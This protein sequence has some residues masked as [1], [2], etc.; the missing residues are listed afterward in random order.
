VLL[1]AEHNTANVFL[2]ISPPSGVAAG[3][4][5]WALTAETADHPLQAAAAQLT[6][7]RPRLVAAT[8][9][10]RPVRKRSRWRVALITGLL[11]AW[12]V[13]LKLGI[14]HG[15]H[16]GPSIR[17]AQAEAAQGETAQGE[18]ASEPLVPN[19]SR[20]P[21]EV[22]GQISVIAGT[23]LAATEG[24]QAEV[25]RL[26]LSALSGSRSAGEQARRTG[27]RVRIAKD[28]WTVRLP[29]GLFTVTFHLKGFEPMSVLVDT[30]TSGS[31]QPE[32]I[33]LIS[34]PV[35][36]GTPTASASGT[37]RAPIG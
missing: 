27:H 13:A 24:V 10:P 20:Q 31:P 7:Q 9:A 14:E 1:L 16:P 35:P 30:V 19:L 25:Y 26:P 32:P 12:L 28:L 17:A 36:A 18:A 37:G 22:R 23:S 29:P 8:D 15:R 34:E 5:Q 11:V 33:T 2:Y 4:Y 21:I 3:R 6:V